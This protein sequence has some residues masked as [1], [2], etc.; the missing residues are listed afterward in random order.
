VFVF[1]Q[2]IK[3]DLQTSTGLK[4]GVF[5]RV[6]IPSSP[7]LLVIASILKAGCKAL[8]FFGL[9]VSECAKLKSQ[10]DRLLQTEFAFYFT[11]FNDFG[12]RFIMFGVENSLTISPRQIRACLVG[13]CF[14]MSLNNCNK[15]WYWRDSYHTGITGGCGS[16]EKTGLRCYEHCTSEYDP[17]G[18]FRCVQ[19]CPQS[20]PHSSALACCASPGCFPIGWTSC[21]LRNMD[22]SAYGTISN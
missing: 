14:T 2:G 15:K 5:F 19:F 13:A 8:N 21:G 12:L 1:F 16:W 22:V 3:Q 11:S 6:Q 7:V 4:S 10:L 17:Q 20:H 9:L 18:Y